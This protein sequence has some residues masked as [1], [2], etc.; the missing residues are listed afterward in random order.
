LRP[1]FRSRS[2]WHRQHFAWSSGRT[3]SSNEGAEPA[4]FATG[5]SGVRA[6]AQADP[7]P[8][9]K[10]ASQRACDRMGSTTSRQRVHESGCRADS[11]DA[12]ARFYFTAAGVAK[13]KDPGPMPPRRGRPD[14]SATLFAS[15]ARTAR[16]VIG[17]RR[18]VGSRELES[19]S[20]QASPF[21]R[22][23]RP[24][25]AIGNGAD[26]PS[27]QSK[28]GIFGQDPGVNGALNGPGMN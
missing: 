25:D 2:P 10:S 22:C 17:H 27:R 7:V 6:R 16:Q 28:R 5:S 9:T 11:R 20:R 23:S 12:V 15:S 4:L 3:V 1:A 13:Q 14:A 19:G 24:N 8:K 26:T 18:E 21:W